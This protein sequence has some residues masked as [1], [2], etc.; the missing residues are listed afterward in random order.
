MFKPILLSAI[1]FL[2]GCFVEIPVILST[3]SEEKSRIVNPNRETQ[4]LLD[5]AFGIWGIS[6]RLH[7]PAIDRGSL[8][9][10]LVNLEKGQKLS[11]Q[12]LNVALCDEAIW[13]DTHWTFLAHEIGHA[14]GIS[15]SDHHSDEFN[16]M[17]FEI[18]P[19]LSDEYYI[20]E[21]QFK[22]VNRHAEFFTSCTW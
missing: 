6:Y 20:T 8:K 3:S 18:D 12:H 22:K 14:F 11:G 15:G 13:S 7:D 5:D 9:I 1:T 16:L 2:C 17:H 4:E 10:I 19:K 21:E